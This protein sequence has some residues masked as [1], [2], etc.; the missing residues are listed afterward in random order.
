[1]KQKEMG[2]SSTGGPV[3]RTHLAVQG[4]QVGSLLWE[5]PTWLGAAQPVHNCC[6]RAAEPDLLEQSHHNEKPARCSKE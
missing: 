4:V 6:A 2:A 1:M 3:V 5:D